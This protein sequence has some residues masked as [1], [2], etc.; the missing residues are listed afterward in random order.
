[1]KGQWI[2]FAMGFARPFLVLRELIDGKSQAAAIV[3]PE[4]F[5][6]GSHR[7]R[8]SPYDGQ[9]YVAGSQGWANYGVDDGSL[10]RVRY[11]G[12][13]YPYPSSYETRENGLLLH[14]DQSQSRELADKNLWF[15]QQWNYRYSAAY[16]SKEYSVEQPMKK[17]HDR[18]KIKS[19][20][21]LQD[22]KKSFL[23]FHRFSP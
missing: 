15:A 9:L 12:G 14:F 22:G 7:G 5:K 13:S 6:S 21:Y 4:E 2:H 10:Q 1:M 23:R 17:G 20:Q 16:G 3:L 11:T 18:L 19:V 8:F